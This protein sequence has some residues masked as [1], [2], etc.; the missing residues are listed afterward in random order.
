MCVQNEESKE[1]PLERCVKIFRP[2]TKM[3]S[4][5]WGKYAAQWNSLSEVNNSNT[6]LIENGGSSGKQGIFDYGASFSCDFIRCKQT[7]FSYYV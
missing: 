7:F 3:F 4:A 2:R 6:I 5:V 1:V